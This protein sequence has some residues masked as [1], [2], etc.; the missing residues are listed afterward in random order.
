MAA[1]SEKVYYVEAL[2]LPEQN[3]N[4]DNSYT[5]LITD[6]KLTFFWVK[7]VQMVIEMKK[8]DLHRKFSANLNLLK[9]V[10]R[11]WRIGYTCLT[12]KCFKS[13]KIILDLG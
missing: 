1:K 4:F 9:T 2:L 8:L 7:T 12:I 3:E 13:L 10:S 6:M 11:Q 5:M